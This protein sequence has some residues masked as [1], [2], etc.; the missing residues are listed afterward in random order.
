MP[1]Q[2]LFIKVNTSKKQITNLTRWADPENN[3]QKSPKVQNEHF[4][5]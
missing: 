2:T 1:E 4:C 5:G 3:G